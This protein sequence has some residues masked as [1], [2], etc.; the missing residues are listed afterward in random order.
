MQKTTKKNE[1]W[2]S[3][4]QTSLVSPHKKGNKHWVGFTKCQHHYQLVSW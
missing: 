2:S 4:S 1:E 3:A